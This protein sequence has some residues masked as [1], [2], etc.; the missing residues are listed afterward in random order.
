MNPGEREQITKLANRAGRHPEIDYSE[1]TDTW[2]VKYATSAPIVGPYE[3]VATML[4]T[5]AKMREKL[6]IPKWVP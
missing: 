1:E 6:G 2:S 3:H 4:M 5:R